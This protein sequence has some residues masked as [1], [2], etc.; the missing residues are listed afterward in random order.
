MKEIKPILEALLLA[1]EAPLSV[2]KIRDI[3]PEAERDEINRQLT[4]LV[5]EY[6]ARNGG[7]H[8]CAVAGGYQFRTRPDFSAWIK[9]LKGARTQILSPAA[10][11]TLAVVAYRQ[12]VM[13][14]EV[15]KIRGVDSSASVK[16]LLDKKIIR[17]VGRKDVPG[18]PMLYGTT[19]KFLEM[20]NLNDLSELPTLRELKE[21][22]GDSELQAHLDL[23]AL[24]ENAESP[25]VREVKQ[26]AG[27]SELPVL[28]ESREPEDALALPAPQD[29]KEREGGEV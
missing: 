26:P 2:E 5:S 13:K 16:G 20:F 14:S 18:K 17:M 10:M 19:K 6:E 25:T 29:L 15:D 11:E 21:L 24:G 28:Q 3:L 1:S 4:E 22:E 8:L 23:K 12:P 27:N 7:F 9:K